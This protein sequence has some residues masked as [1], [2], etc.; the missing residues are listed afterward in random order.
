MYFQVFIKLF[1]TKK[2]E[3]HSKRTDPNKKVQIRP[4]PEPQTSVLEYGPKPSNLSKILLKLPLPWTHKVLNKV[5]KELI[6]AN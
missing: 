5:S 2:I 4:D 3:L 6:N 1:S